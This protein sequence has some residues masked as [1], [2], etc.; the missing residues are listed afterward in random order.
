[1]ERTTSLRKTLTGIDGLDEIT[2]G[3]LPTGRTTLV[4]GGAGSGKTMLAVEFLI[5][6][7]VDHGEPGVF[8]AFEET[9]KDLAENFASLGYDLEQ[10]QREGTLL[11]DHVHLDADEIV[12]GVGY[13]LEGLFIRLGHAIELVGA[14]RVVLDTIEVL[15]STLGNTGLVRSEFLRLLR[16]LKGRGMTAIVT[17]ERGENLLTRFGLEEYVADCVIL[18]DHRVEDQISTRRVRVVK[19]R[20]SLHEMD[21]H[22][23]LMA[24]NGISVLPIT[25]IGLSHEVSKERISTGILRLDEML[26]GKGFFRGSSILVSGTAGV[27]KSSLALSF[28]D[29][30]CKRGE[31][32][33]YFGFEESEAQSVR[34]MQSIGLDLRRS[35]ESGLLHFIAA[36]PSS[37]GLEAHLAS[38]HRAIERYKPSV[39]VLD[40]I[41][42]FMSGSDKAP[43]KSMLIRMVDY[44]KTRQI[45][46]LLTHLS[47]SEQHPESTEQRVSS[48]MDTWILLRDLERDGLR[49]SAL[50]VLKSRGMPHSRAMVGFNLTDSG[51]YLGDNIHPM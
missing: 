44:L 50:Y 36:R 24:E 32:A 47:N 38:I 51:I 16:W 4:A 22:P 43:V 46:T 13:D 42:N 5:H 31:S 3:G 33:L 45:T 6:G 30:A 48:I 2:H 1:V 14:K 9:E 19:Y 18:L 41:S 25:S 37:L 28:L 11:I 15:F 27:G 8:L 26:G 17:A 7:I 35:V 29:A 12:E 21:E 20:G 34:N 39:V 10:L 23:F 40:P 49:R